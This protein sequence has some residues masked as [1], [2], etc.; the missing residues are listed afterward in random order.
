MLKKYIIS[1][2]VLVIVCVFITAKDRTLY[3]NLY[4]ENKTDW[5]MKVTAKVKDEWDVVTLTN[6]DI[7]AHGA[8]RIDNLF[9]LS[10]IRFQPDIEDDSKAQGWL[11]DSNRLQFNAHEAAKDL[12]VSIAKDPYMDRWNFKQTYVTSAVIEY[13]GAAGYSV[14]VL[15]R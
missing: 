12:I 5:D 2:A 4:I 3:G 10:D 1:S 15:T 13:G 8:E 6:W 7:P 11:A 9:K 14:K